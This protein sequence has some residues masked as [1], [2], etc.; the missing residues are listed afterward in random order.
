[1]KTNKAFSKRLRI[2]R[3]GKIIARK[4][5]QNHFNAKESRHGHM[6]RR[7]T[8]NITVTKKVAQ[9]YIKF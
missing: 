7:R 2:T 4:P 8:Q 5:G 6:N 3:K 9:R 1:M